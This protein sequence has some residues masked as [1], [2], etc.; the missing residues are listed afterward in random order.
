LSTLTT[1]TQ[2]LNYIRHQGLNVYANE[3]ARTHDK[4]LATYKEELFLQLF[5]A[6]E[7]INRQTDFKELTEEQLKRQDKMQADAAE[8]N[9]ALEKERQTREEIFDLTFGWTAKFETKIVD[10]GKELED[11]IIDQLKQINA[12][13]WTPWASPEHPASAA[14]GLQPGKT[15]E[16]WG[17][18]LRPQMFEGGGLQADPLIPRDPADVL[19][20]APGSMGY[21]KLEPPGGWRRSGLVENDS[22]HDQVQAV[23]TNTKEFHD[24]NQRIER[25][26]DTGVFGNPSGATPIPAMARGG[27]VQGPKKVLVGERGREAIVSLDK[28]DARVVDQPTVTTLSNAAVI[29]LNQPLTGDQSIHPNA[30]G[31]IRAIGQTES[32]FS[33]KEA[34]SDATN[35]MSYGNKTS[36][37][38]YGY[39]QMANR[40]VDYAVNKL[41]M[42]REEAQHL[43]G[44]PEHGSTVSQQVT[45]VNDYL[46]RRWPDAYKNLIDK[47]DYEGMRQATRDGNVKWQ[48]FGLRDDPAGAR[49]E[50][51]RTRMAAGAASDVVGAGGFG[52][53]YTG[54]ATV[55]ELPT[56]MAEGGLVTGP[57]SGMAASLRQTTPPAA[58][59]GAGK[60]FLQTAASPLTTAGYYLG[61]LLQGTERFHGAEAVQ[62]AAPLA[63]TAVGSLGAIPGGIGAGGLRG[64]LAG[65]LEGDLAATGEYATVQGIKQLQNVV[66]NAALGDPTATTA[67]AGIKGGLTSFFSNVTKPATNPILTNLDRAAIDKSAA[68]GGAVEG[69]VEVSHQAQPKVP[70]ANRGT[71]LFRSV[72]INRQSQMSHAA[73]G[74]A[75]TFS[76]EE[77]PA[78]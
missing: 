16:D 50:Y 34:Y 38:D 63:L 6:Q 26:I 69:T 33:Y 74:P 28:G 3:F 23:D 11:Q 32:G 77:M 67:G 1:E 4:Q 52:G 37:Y 54:P 18:V 65:A 7:L 13:T 76:Q 8:L 12:G 59:T 21:G 10:I 2:R 20:L 71:P 47:G 58:L 61:G 24:L 53:G 72:R 27:P 55:G 73:G 5:G 56:K 46:Q 48:W 31:F 22:T 14:P 44:G 35:R 66:Q 17:K 62:A 36:M 40:D 68:G 15:K 39:F 78:G 57:E 42:S 29:P 30:L 60:S 51:D 49:A 25:L 43:T 19:G 9:A 64:A 70:N 75:T 41:G 45:A